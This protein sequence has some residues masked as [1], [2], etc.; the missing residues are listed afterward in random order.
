MAVKTIHIIEAKGTV[1]A[2]D[3]DAA[4]ERAEHEIADMLRYDSGECTHLIFTGRDERHG[5][6]YKATVEAEHYTPARWSSFSIRTA[7][8]GTK[9]TRTVRKPC[10]QCR[11]FCEELDA[12]SKAWALRQQLRPQSP[13]RHVPPGV[14][15]NTLNETQ[16]AFFAD[17]EE[18][19]LGVMRKHLS[20]PQW[21]QVIDA[22]QE[23]LYD[24]NKSQLWQVLDSL[25]D[26]EDGPGYLLNVKGKAKV[27]HIPDENGRATCGRV[28]GNE[29]DMK[30][31]AVLPPEYHVCKMC[32]PS[33]MRTVGA[34]EW[35]REI[36]RFVKAMG[37]EAAALQAVLSAGLLVRMAVHDTWVI[38]KPPAP[39][40]PYGER[41]CVCGHNSNA[42]KGGAKQCVMCSCA[43]FS[44]D[45]V[46]DIKCSRCRKNVVTAYDDLCDPC[47]TAQANDSYDKYAKG[48]R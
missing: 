11:G 12:K 15:M 33:P 8:T 27:A 38:D 34:Q 21:D 32:G 7:E 31:S 44:L 4:R 48:S 19:L 40:T 6:H 9:K 18:A 13:R 43:Q 16:E 36:T 26:P 25:G 20:Q 30:R 47:R 24:D 1:V 14:A 5:W 3:Q 10:W 39:T 29:V 2:R 22:V 17:Y 28:D 35:K 37:G 42:H 46:L 23:G 41:M 45:V